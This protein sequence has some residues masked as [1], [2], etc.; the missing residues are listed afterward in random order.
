LSAAIAL[1]TI[2]ITAMAATDKSFP[3]RAKLPIVMVFS[4]ILSTNNNLRTL[5]T[6]RARLTRRGSQA[7]GLAHHDDA[8]IGHSSTKGDER[9]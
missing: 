8:N 2:S 3:A 4:E 9:L 5:A 6:R 7:Q 1:P